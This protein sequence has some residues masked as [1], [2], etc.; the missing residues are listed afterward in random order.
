M[1][2]TAN[3]VDVLLLK[4]GVDGWLHFNLIF[5]V[6]GARLFCPVEQNLSTF[7]QR[8]TWVDCSCKAFQ[9]RDISN[10]TQNARTLI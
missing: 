6:C 7:D 4:D 2:S 5:L 3:L 10:Q 1:D 8:L 9:E